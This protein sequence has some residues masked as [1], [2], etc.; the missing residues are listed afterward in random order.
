MRKPIVFIALALCILFPASLR[1]QLGEVLDVGVNRLHNGDFEDD[2]LDSWYLEVRSDLG[3]AAEW[4]ID[5]KPPPVE[6]EVLW[7]E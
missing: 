4:E 1:A 3:A 7:S 2:P 6:R 5:K